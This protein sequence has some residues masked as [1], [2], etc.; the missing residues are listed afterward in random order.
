LFFSTITEPRTVRAYWTQKDRPMA[1]DDD[2]Q[3]DLVMALHRNDAAHHAVDQQRH[4]I[5]G[6]VS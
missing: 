6:K 3:R 4:Q 1:P 2:E 5:A